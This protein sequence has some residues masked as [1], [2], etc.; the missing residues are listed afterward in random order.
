MNGALVHKLCRKVSRRHCF[1]IS[2]FVSQL[3]LKTIK[4]TPNTGICRGKANVTVNFSNRSAVTAPSAHLPKTTGRRLRTTQLG[5]Q[6]F[7][8]TWPNINKTT[9]E[10]LENIPVTELLWLFFQ[11]FLLLGM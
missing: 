7:C 10:L 1:V 9:L 2:S 3:N 11:I 6:A 5:S 4:F 8:V